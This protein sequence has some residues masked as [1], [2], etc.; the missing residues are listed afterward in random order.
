MLSVIDMVKPEARALVA[1]MSAFV[2]ACDAGPADGP[3]PYAVSDSAGIQIVE[4]ISATWP[5]GDRRVDPDP[6]LQI[7]EEEQGPYQF[8]Y[9]AFGILEDNGAI[10]VAELASQELRAFDASGQHI[11]TFGRS[12]SGPGEFEGLAG[13]HVYRGD[14]LAAYD[15]RLNRITVLDDA[16]SSYRSF[17]HR[18]PG[19]YGVFGVAQDSVFMLFSPGGSYRPDLQ[20]GLQ[21]V[22]TDIIAM[23]SDGEHRVVGQ[24]PDRQRRVAPDGNA[25]M[26]QPLHYA[27]QAAAPGGFYWATP[28]RYEIAFYDTDG[29]LRRML[30]RPIERR[31]VEPGMIQQYIE[32]QLDRIRRSQ[33][34]DAVAAYRPR[35]DDEQFGESLPL[36][37]RALVDSDG[38]LWLAGTTWPGTGP[39]S[40]WSVFSPEGFLLGDVELPE[41][42]TPLDSRG[43]TLLA[44]WLDEFDVP[45]LQLRRLLSP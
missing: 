25:P 41:R 42:L 14:S 23:R 10:V 38:R 12:G 40:R 39:P 6:L 35:Y 22:M 37:S 34:E 2:P 4:S 3:D 8:S 45:H 19:N 11:A 32:L 33:G 24:L 43:D 1:L 31:P 36:F 9:I 5:G 13:L 21:W 27:V 26:P 28:D 16:F 18:I 7:G 15:A 44:V 29:T 30:R 17:V 20:P